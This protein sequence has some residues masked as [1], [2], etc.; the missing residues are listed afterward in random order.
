MLIFTNV[1]SLFQNGARVFEQ[2]FSRLL[3]NDNP[4][5]YQIY[6]RISTDLKGI[7]QLTVVQ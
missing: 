5:V 2:K 7:Y 6:N 1:T 4:P 3:T